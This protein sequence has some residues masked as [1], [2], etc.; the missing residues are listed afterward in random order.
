MAAAGTPDTVTFSGGPPFCNVGG[1]AVFVEGKSPTGSR[2]ACVS[3]W[4]AFDMVGNLE[5]WVADWKED[6]RD[7]GSTIAQN[8]LLFGDD[9]INSVDEADPVALHQPAAILRGGS[10]MLSGT[11]HD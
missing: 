11:L 10:L 1:T 2:A 3:N 4:G 9:K 8:T 7:R 6:N 5:E